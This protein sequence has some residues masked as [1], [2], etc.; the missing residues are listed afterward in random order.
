MVLDIIKEQR[1]VL[2]PL[3]S[4]S[5]FLIKWSVGDSLTLTT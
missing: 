5:L 2:A 1:Q 4:G 3:F